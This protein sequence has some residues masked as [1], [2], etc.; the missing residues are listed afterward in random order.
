M[1]SHNFP[2]LGSVTK[3]LALECKPTSGFDN[4]Q[5]RGEDP[6][7]AKRICENSNAVALLVHRCY[8]QDHR[9]RVCIDK[10]VM[11]AGKRGS[12][13]DAPLPTAVH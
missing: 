8:V 6:P 9:V 4:P 11:V 1:E 2:R 3:Y 13:L 5:A 7:R 12:G 10:I